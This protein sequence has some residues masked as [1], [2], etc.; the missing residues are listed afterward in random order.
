MNRRGFIKS[1]GYGLFAIA[2]GLSSKWLLTE[3]P[4]PQYW[5]FDNGT[6]LRFLNNQNEW[7][8]IG[9]TGSWED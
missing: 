5:Q 6:T 1:I 3:P 2:S 4:V 8:L 7:E 9:V